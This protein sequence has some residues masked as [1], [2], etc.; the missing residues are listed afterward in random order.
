[1][2][3]SDVINRIEVFKSLVTGKDCDGNHLVLVGLR[4]DEV[5]VDCWRSRLVFVLW[6]VFFGPH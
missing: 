2:S 1:M 3:S 5:G 4:D 6:G